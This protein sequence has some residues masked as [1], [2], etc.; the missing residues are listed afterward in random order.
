MEDQDR[1]IPTGGSGGGDS[2]EAGKGIDLTDNPE[3]NKKIVSVKLAADG[4][5]EFTE[6]GSIRSTGGSGGDTI[7]AGEGIKVAGEGTK[8]V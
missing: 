6:D 2:I 8:T 4:G 5:L 3:N 1:L 7:V